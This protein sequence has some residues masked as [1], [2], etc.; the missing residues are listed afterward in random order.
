M[1]QRHQN[2]EHT[3]RD[4]RGGLVG[5]TGESRGGVKSRNMYKGPI[6]NDSVV[7][8]VFEIGGWT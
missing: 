6:D 2:K 8:N 1:H 3:D 7:E 4:K 5:I